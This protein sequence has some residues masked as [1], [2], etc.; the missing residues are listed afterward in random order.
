MPQHAQTIETGLRQLDNAGDTRR[1]KISPQER[2]FHA[3]NELLF[4]FCNRIGNYPSCVGP[5]TTSSIPDE[6]DIMASIGE[7][8]PQYD[9]LKCFVCVFVCVLVDWLVGVF[10]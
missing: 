10:G 5:G 7:A 2:I 3:A 8:H 6:E 4:H 9:L 1:K